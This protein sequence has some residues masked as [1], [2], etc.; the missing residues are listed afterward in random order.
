MVYLLYG[1]EEFLI[2]EKI[3]EITKKYQA[4]EYNV[5][6]Y[7]LAETLLEDIIKDAEMISLFNEYKVIIASNADIFLSTKSAQ[8]H[9]INA[10]EGYLKN[11]NEKTILIF[12]VNAEKLDER[13]KIV[14]LIK[15]KGQ[16]LEFNK[17]NNIYQFVKEKFDDYEISDK[18][19]LTFI[20]R[21]GDNLAFIN[22]E[23]S[24]LKTY[25]IDEKKI[26]EEDVLLLINKNIDLDIFHF[27]DNIISKNSKDALATYHELLKTK[28]EPTNVIA[29]LANQIRIMYQSKELSQMGYSEN[30]IAKELNI[31]P[32]RV[33]LALQKSYQYRSDT[34]LSYLSK[35][36]DLEINIKSGTIDKDTALELFILNI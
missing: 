19:L 24:K 14:K 1:L 12:T 21:V 25:K 6:D 2:N 33:K 4:C 36:A 27:I 20:N 18:A 16:V 3:K 29:M 5:S 7:S 13:K 10:L 23:I 34:L 26:T 9:D 35:L 31:H 11:I 28:K 15:E 30:N 17:V 32:Y 8:N 22:K